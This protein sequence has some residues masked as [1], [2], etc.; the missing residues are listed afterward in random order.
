MPEGADNLIL[1][2][3]PILGAAVDVAALLWDR[4]TMTAWL[5]L[6]VNIAAGSVTVFLALLA[7]GT[8]TDH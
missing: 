4:R 7:A 8:P 5:G 1:V 6:L 3:L 2:G